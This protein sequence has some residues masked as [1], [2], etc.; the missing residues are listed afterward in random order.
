MILKNKGLK[1]N[2]F[3]IFLILL[4]IAFIFSFSAL[5]QGVIT[6]EDFGR[7][8]KILC[9]DTDD[10]GDCWDKNK[11]INPL[12]PGAIRLEAPFGEIAVQPDA[13]DYCVNNRTELVE[14][15]CKI[16]GG[17]SFMEIDS[18][19]CQWGCVRRIIGDGTLFVQTPAYCNYPPTIYAMYEKKIRV[20]FSLEFTVPAED[21]N[22]DKLTFSAEYLKLPETEFQEGLPDGATLDEN[23]GEFS[24]T[25]ERGQEGNYKIKF[26]AT[27]IHGL[28]DEEILDVYVGSVCYDSDV[29]FSDVCTL[30]YPFCI[31]E[32]L[33]GTATYL[34]AVGQE[35]TC[36]GN[37]LREKY[38]LNEFEVREQIPYIS[39]E[40]DCVVVE[41]PDFCNCP[42]EADDDSA[43]VDEDS[44]DNEIDVLEN[45]NDAD[46]DEL[47]ITEVSDPLHGTATHDEKYVYYT[48]DENYNGEDSFT[49]T[50]ADLLP[51]GQETSETDTTTITITIT[52]FNDAPVAYDM[53]V[54]VDE[55]DVTVIEL[56]ATDAENDPLTFFIIDFPLH[57][58]AT[59]N[60][61]E[62]TYVPYA[63]YFGEDSF[64]FKAN[65][66]EFDSNVATVYITVTPINDAPVITPVDNQQTNEGILLKVELNATDI[67]NEWED[68]TFSLESGPD[69]A[70]VYYA[71][72]EDK[73]WFEWIPGYGDADEYNDVII[74]VEDD[75]TPPLDDSTIFNITVK[76]ILGFLEIATLKEKLSVGENVELTDP[77]LIENKEKKLN[78]PL[79]KTRAT[80]KEKNTVTNQPFTALRKIMQTIT[81]SYEIDK[82]F[83]FSDVE[84]I[85]DYVYME[86]LKNSQKVG[87]PVLPV[88]TINI[89][90]PFDSKVKDID[91]LV[92]NKI[93]L[94]GNYFVK[95]AQKPY[96][97]SYEGEIEITKPDSR[98]YDSMDAYPGKLYNIVSR[99][100]VKGYDILIVNLYPVHYVPKLGQ[101]YYYDGMEIKISASGG[102]TSMSKQE[103][104]E[105]NFRNLGKDKEDIAGFIDNPEALAG[106]DNLYVPPSNDKGGNDNNRGRFGFGGGGFL[107]IP[108][109]ETNATY[110]YMVI[111]KKDLNA[112]FQPLLEWKE[113]KGLDTVIA[114]TEDILADPDYNCDGVWGDGCAVS[115]FNDSQARIRNFI[116]DAYNTWEIDYVVLG[117]D[118]EII[119]DRLFYPT[120]SSSKKYS[121]PSDLYYAA[122]DG[123]WNNDTDTRFGEI[124]AAGGSAGDEADLYAEVY[125]GRVTVE[126]TT[127][128]TN[129]VNKVIAYENATMNNDAYLKKAVMV[130]EELDSITWGGNSKDR[131]IDI[132][133]QYNHK[134]LY[135]RDGTFS[136]TAVKNEMNNGSHL[137]NHV[138]HSNY[139][140]VMHLVRDDVDALTNTEYFLAYSIGCISAGFDQWMSGDGE[141]IGEHF[142]Y[143]DH[144]AFAYIG[145]T[146]YGWYSPGSTNGPGDR[147]DRAFFTSI[148]TNSTHTGK[149]M[150]D[151]KRDMLGA[152]HDRWTH[153]TSLLFGCPE[154]QL[155]ISFTTPTA[156]FLYPAPESELKGISNINGTAKSGDETNST[157]SYY[158]IKYGYG[159]N[160]SQWYTAGINLTDNGT[161][162]K[163]KEK[164]AEFDTSYVSDGAIKLRLKAYDDYS[165]E[166]IDYVRVHVKN[167]YISSPED[168]S[169]FKPGISI[170][171]TGNAMGS[172]FTNYTLEYGKGENPGTWNLIQFSTT[173]VEEGFLGT[174]NTSSINEHD[175]YTIRLTV[176]NIGGESTDKVKVVLDPLYKQGWPQEVNYR[177]IAG[178]V[179]VADLDVDAKK[180]ILAGESGT[181]ASKNFYVW[182]ANGN[183][184]SGWPKNNVD[185]YNI[186]STPAITDI[187]D[188]QDLEIFI[189]TGS[190]YKRVYS[191]HHNAS[192][193]SGWY[194]TT[195]AEVFS[196]IGIADID[197]DDMAEIIGVA[198]DRIYAWK[199]NGTLMWHKDTTWSSYSSPAIGDINGD[200]DHEIVL[201]AQNKL[202]AWDVSGNAV[203]GFPKTLSRPTVGSPVMADLDDDGDNEIIV[204]NDKVYIIDGNG[205]IIKSI[206]LNDGD[207]DS[208]PAIADIDNDGELEIITTTEDRIYALNL[209]GSNV[210]GWPVNVSY[211]MDFSAVVV[212][213]VDG[214]NQYEVVATSCSQYGDDDGRIYMYNHD[215][216]AV[217][218]WP[219]IVPDSPS[220]GWSRATPVID[221]I[222][223]DG[224]VEIVL[225]DE[226]Y[227]L[228]WQLDGE[229]NQT[230]MPWPSFMHDKENTG[231]YSICGNNQI[232][233]H[234]EC[235]GTDDN[236]CENRCSQSCMCLPKSMV[237]NTASNNITGYLLMKV[238]KFTSSWVDE[239][240]IVNDTAL[241]IIE[242]NSYLALDIVWNDSGAYTTTEQG[243]FRVYT[244]LRDSLGN[245]IEAT[246][247]KK[248]EDYYIFNVV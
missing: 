243:K 157:F 22:L 167:V 229:Y 239:E 164:L 196:G 188:D 61:S 193:V 202:Y 5:P 143:D 122:L 247:G 56:N 59:L 120:S 64:T 205:T 127:E 57:G 39:C 165:G 60:D 40:C 207:L 123:N 68:F 137:F 19:H 128:V 17:Y 30:E 142:V 124:P 162:E 189:G 89:L 168:Y 158:E 246:D 104:Q 231:V 244:A 212:G 96:P 110:D 55:D 159:N 150:E 133:P 211:S 66:G 4:A 169:Y 132:I 15:Y 210:N 228:V 238:Q 208:T 73:W 11:C 135:E 35:D 174:W 12:I 84:I 226:N 153:Y 94:D 72:T 24:W 230:K 58:N 130:G 93:T 79:K 67:D 209:D 149:A 100:K 125:L 97:T 81:N 53:Y 129:W 51:N 222:D 175:Y 227:L 26:I 160:P 109:N 171:I 47:I 214:D 151:S 183:A 7:D 42:P 54:S 134:T 181:W 216:T 182:D 232:E 148:M 136:G 201:L 145:N 31:D 235:D 224:D 63:N 88:K 92:G 14:Y 206:S 46:N 82:S 33:P 220:G 6:Q 115:Q 107:S 106:Y 236:T 27:D 170:N 74:M 98:I 140:G 177:L 113:A 38:C 172:L 13:K 50:L 71:S 95:P 43:V 195:N 199:E 116:K 141:A 32:H 10:N 215:G 126:T 36:W 234:E 86:G 44:I 138:G 45:D 204:N 90:L 34:G 21:P 103:A 191:W 70:A 213:D 219:R 41:G 69:D 37:Q 146:R 119:D 200:G 197:S 223:S 1:R 192:S 156:N 78:K 139:G 83:D 144:A 25:P 2:N 105:N 101:I 166:G 203:S 29:E 194:K 108:G 178:S 147:Y 121:I 217:S 237:N 186:R 76:D 180:E 102:K 131:V 18:S 3:W 85:S 77:P 245:P 114:F 163:D 184:M 111:T 152:G 248:L 218:G 240:I 20:G 91:V 173:P 179:G 161:I 221:D 185:Y 8:S 75:G 198:Y 87:E 155:K 187:D 99:Q 80:S 23:S 65:D 176:N 52:A 241:R 28:F 62:V 233:G 242:G 117:G 154:T 225:G 16:K 49:Y 9:K 112:S 118:D 190:L 48:P